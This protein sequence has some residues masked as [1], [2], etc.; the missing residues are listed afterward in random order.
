VESQKQIILEMKKTLSK[1]NMNETLKQ[2]GNQIPLNEQQA[3]L[4]TMKTVGPAKKTS[5][6]PKLARKSTGRL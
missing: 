1:I 6:V 3:K 4:K 5:E 2:S